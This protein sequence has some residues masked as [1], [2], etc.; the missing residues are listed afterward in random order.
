METTISWGYIGIIWGFLYVYRGYI[1][2]ILGMRKRVI[3]LNMYIG[4]ILGLYWGYVYH[5]MLGF[6]V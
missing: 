1:K 6:G 2:V 4:V 5:G 3:Y